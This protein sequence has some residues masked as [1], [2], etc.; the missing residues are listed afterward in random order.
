M[1]AGAEG[2]RPTIDQSGELRSAAI[3]GLR[4]LAAIGVLRWAETSPAPS[5]PRLGP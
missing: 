3:E 4:A 2:P 5:E 1:S